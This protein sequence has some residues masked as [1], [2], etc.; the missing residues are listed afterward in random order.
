MHTCQLYEHVITAQQ[1]VFAYGGSIDQLQSPSHGT[2]HIHT[3]GS[4]RTSNPHSLTSQRAFTR[5]FLSFVPQ[6]QRMYSAHQTQRSNGDSQKGSGS[7]TKEIPRRVQKGASQRVSTQGLKKG[8]HRR[9]AIPSSPA[10]VYPS[11]EENIRLSQEFK[12]RRIPYAST[13]DYS[14]LPK[15]LY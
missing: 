1:G 2:A 12:I 7:N 3:I 6:Q 9:D 8:C 11:A 14:I 5:M 15:L 10:N 13:L 4:A